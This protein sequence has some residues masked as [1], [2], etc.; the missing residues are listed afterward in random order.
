MSL[1]CAM[2]AI[3]EK[4]VCLYYE[5]GDS[6]VAQECTNLETAK[7][8]EADDMAQNACY[9]DTDDC[10]VKG[11]GGATDPPATSTPAPEGGLKCLQPGPDETLMSLSC[12]MG[13]ITEKA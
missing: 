9:C 5:Y 13:A 4:A 6:G 1:S 2:G 7:T 8:L 11:C 3:T 10:N 12:A